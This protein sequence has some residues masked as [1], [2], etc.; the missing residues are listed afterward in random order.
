[1]NIYSQSYFKSTFCKTSLHFELKKA[2]GGQEATSC[3]CAGAR[4]KRCHF[5]TIPRFAV[6]QNKGDDSPEKLSCELFGQSSSK[7]GQSAR[8]VSGVP[9]PDEGTLKPFLSCGLRSGTIV[10]LLGIRARQPSTNEL[11]PRL[12][13]WGTRII[14]GLRGP[15][16]L[17]PPGDEACI[18]KIREHFSSL[19]VASTVAVRRLK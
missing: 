12:T 7:N 14:T 9:L 13:T 11:A 8:V 2:P 17:A 18:G 5:S 15:A 16:I 1:M 10:P 3:P 19:G 6:L 4:D